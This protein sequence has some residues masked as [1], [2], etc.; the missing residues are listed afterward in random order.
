MMRYMHSRYRALYFEEHTRHEQTKEKLVKLRSLAR[1]CIALLKAHGAL[2]ADLER[3]IE[4]S[5]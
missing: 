2:C 1:K 5:V 4:S 3:E